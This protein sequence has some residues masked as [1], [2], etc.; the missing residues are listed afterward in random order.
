VLA[1]RLFTRL[2]ATDAMKC[3]SIIDD[4]TGHPICD[5]DTNPRTIVEYLVRRR[6][7]R[8]TADFLS[9]SNKPRYERL[10]VI[11]NEQ[12]RAWIVSA[13]VRCT[14]YYERG[15]WRRSWY[16]NVEI[17]PAPASD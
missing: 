11:N 16:Q 14:T 6:R 9:S 7:R 13:P 3:F 15:E 17:H 1:P 4:Q 5:V 2:K 10:R 12:T 8:S